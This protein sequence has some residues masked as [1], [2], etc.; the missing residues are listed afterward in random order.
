MSYKIS[1]HSDIAKKSR[2]NFQIPI[3]VILMI[4]A[5]TNAVFYFTGQGIPLRE[6]LFPWV[7][8]EIREAFSTFVEEL[9]EGESVIACFESFCT[10]VFDESNGHP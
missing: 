5:L 3:A 8:P 6:Y 9:E 1:Y 10:D 4:L 7:K 2:L